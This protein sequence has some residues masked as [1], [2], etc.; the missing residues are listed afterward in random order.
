M[1]RILA[2]THTPPWPPT[3]GGHQRTNLLLRA[4]S[5]CGKVDLVLL[6]R[7]P[8][9]H[10][11]ELLEQLEQHF[12]LVDSLVP[13]PRG[14]HGLWSLIR[15]LSPKWVD[16]F[17][18]LFGSAEVDYTPDP[19]ATRSLEDRLSVHHYNVVV[20]RYLQPVVRA[21]ALSFAPLILD[22][23]DLD[24]DRAR[25]QLDVAGQAPWTKWLLRRRLKALERIVPNRL[26]LPDQLWV[27]SEADRA[28]VGEDRAT[29][30]PNIPFESPDAPAPRPQPPQPDCKRILFVGSLKFGVN[31]RGIDNFLRQAWPIIRRAHPSATFRIVGGGLS[32]RQRTRWRRCPGVEPVGFVDNLADEYA[33]CAFTVVPL[34][35]G[36]GTKIKVMESLARGRTGVVARHAHRGFEHALRDRESLWVA[37][38]DT[39]VAEGC[40]ALL[41]DPSLPGSMAEAGRAQVAEHFTFDRFASIVAKTV[42]NALRN[43]AKGVRRRP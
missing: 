32:D 28:A 10:P 41:S 15:P 36:G 21:G 11:P 27:C 31:E 35:E 19:L 3:N 30:L 25:T 14:Q 23:D 43:D 6:P 2:V 42:E 12:Q 34:F 9:R 5:R 39:G 40:N 16:R 18:G 22:V 33:A 24:T 8:A 29:V 1:T 20:G 17:A 7:S 4:L 26:T 13:T 38:N 37:E